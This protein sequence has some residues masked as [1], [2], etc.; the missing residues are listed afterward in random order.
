MQQYNLIAYWPGKGDGKAKE[1]F[2]WMNKVTKG[3]QKSIY[4]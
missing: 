4:Y 3:V 1:K 2:N